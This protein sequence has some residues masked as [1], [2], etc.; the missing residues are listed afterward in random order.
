MN[1]FMAWLDEFRRR[2][3][4]PLRVLHI[5]NIANNAYINAT[6]QRRYGIEADVICYDYYHVMACPEWVDHEFTGA[7]DANLP[8]WWST[9]L[10]GWKRPPWFAQGP[11]ALCVAYLAAYRGGHRGKAIRLWRELERSCRA[12]AAPNPRRRSV[13]SALA[14]LIAGIRARASSALASIKA[15]ASIKRYDL[16]LGWQPTLRGTLAVLVVRSLLQL[17]REIRGYVPTRSAGPWESARAGVHSAGT[18]AAV[19]IGAE[20]AR[21][22]PAEL[23]KRLRS[24]RFAEIYAR[25]LPDVQKAVRD[26]DLAYVETVA[27]GWRELMCQYDIVQGYSIDGYIPLYNG[28]SRYAAY[29]H[30]TLRT[31]P[32]DPTLVGRLCRLAYRHAAAVFVTNVDVLPSTEKLS[33]DQASVVRLPHAC[34]DRDILGVRA[35]NPTCRPRA[36]GV[37]TFLAPARHHWSSGGPSLEKGNDLLIRAAARLYAEGARFEVILMEWG[38]DVDRTR[39]LITNLGCEA[40]FRWVP[41]KNKRELWKAFLEAHGVLNQFR[42]PGIGGVDFEAL[43]LGCRLITRVDAVVL[44]RFFGVGPPI[45]AASTD[46]EIAGQMRRVIADP[47][48]HEGIGRRSRDWA[49]GCHSSERVVALQAAAYQRM[50]GDATAQ[51]L[52]GVVAARSPEHTP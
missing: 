41:P 28:I 17:G 38:Q 13:P 11:T 1:D 45:L 39:D 15:R 36:D 5:G 19:T 12:L 14:P 40:V 30:G 16:P 3:G 49:Q 32:F 31:I 18:P 50:L 2:R 20:Q 10:G 42:I 48:D 37:I 7:I 29:E 43:T 24:M 46:E 23:E 25:E 21:L 35:A 22:G 4:R 33:L 8:D 26:A 52:T 9:S 51:P 6:I 44:E 27:G 34:D 47:D